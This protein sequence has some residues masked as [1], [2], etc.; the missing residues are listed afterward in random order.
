MSL[1]SICAV[2]WMSKVSHPRQQMSSAR[3]GYP[4]RSISIMAMS[5]SG[6]SN[7]KTQ[8]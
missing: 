5:R 4:S 7:L 3:N 1:L 6:S 2:C 8:P